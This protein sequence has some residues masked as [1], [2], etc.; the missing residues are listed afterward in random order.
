MTEQ[1]HTSLKEGIAK[2]LEDLK[3]DL[4]RF[5]TGRASLS[6]LDGVSVSYYGSRTPLSGVASL[7]IP[8]P[9][10]IL[11]KP[12]EKSQL[13]EIEKAIIEANLG[14]TPMNDGEVIRLPMPAMT[15]QRRK[16]LAKQ[17]K[18][19]GE[20]HK[21]AIRNLRRDANEQLK[22]QLKDKEITEDDNKRAQE[23]VQKETDAGT[24]Q[25]DEIVAK[26]EKEVMEV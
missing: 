17:V 21:V 16:E 3:R 19:A 5:R 10:L 9:R 14:I 7:T 24:A 11:V 6:I 15:E 20:E 12:W 13:K 26:K 8:E 2:A 4:G 1:V 22:Q 25:V 18:A 23:K